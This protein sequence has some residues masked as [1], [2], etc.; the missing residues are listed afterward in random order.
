M[1][2]IFSQALIVFFFS[3]S[4][5]PLNVQLK[6]FIFNNSHI[7]I[8]KFLILDEQF[9][10]LSEK[11]FEPKINNLNTPSIIGLEDVRLINHNNQLYY[12]GNKNIDFEYFLI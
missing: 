8:N 7:T 5:K 1:F 12:Y 4:V 11:I 10:I 3:I 2:F 9:N 6:C